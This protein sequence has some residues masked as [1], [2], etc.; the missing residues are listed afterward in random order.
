MR[1]GLLLIVPRSLRQHAVSTS[2]T[3]ASTALA[4]GLVMAVFALNKQT[5]DAFTGGPAGFDAVLG[6]RGSQLQLVLNAVFHLETSPGNIPWTLYQEVKKDAQVELAIPYAVGDNYHGFRIVGTEVEIFS[7]FRYQEDRTF[8]FAPG[9]RAFDPAAREAVLGSFAAQSTG[10][11]LGDYFHPYHGLT[12][13]ESKKH[14]ERYLVVGIL[15]PTNSPSDRAIWIPIEGIFRMEGHVIRGTG[16]EYIAEAGK[17]IPDEA[18]EVSAVL[19]KFKDPAL[20]FAFAQKI[21]RQGTL[22]TLAWPIDLV[23]ADL[24]N[25][26]GWVVR[27]LELVAYLVVLVAAGSILASLYNTMNE[28]RRE[29]AIL[30][31]LGARR[32]TVSAAIVSEAAAIALLGSILG[33]AVYAAIL[34][35]AAHVIR[36]QT[37][38]VLVPLQY[39]PVLW[40]APLGMVVLGAFAGIL[41]AWKAYRTDVA[42]GLQPSN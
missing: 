42:T 7:E 25:K 39:H 4:C 16:T 9:G 40:A 31:A 37:G 15:E 41:P 10:L 32:S 28:R 8:A 3:V 1:Q 34:A 38:V 30:R 21:N 24:F 13:D 20:G 36:A 26:L 11:R 12:F 19:I 22:A 23:M 5:F 35:V 17:P 6:A 2:V 27:I 33:F 14:N 18:K 29:F